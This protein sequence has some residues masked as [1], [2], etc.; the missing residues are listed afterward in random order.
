M[1]EFKKAKPV[2]LVT[3]SLALA[4]VNSVSNKLP[5]TTISVGEKK[6]RSGQQITL[7]LIKDYAALKSEENHQLQASIF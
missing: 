1:S 7:H 2:I 4:S 6:S 5:C 3:D